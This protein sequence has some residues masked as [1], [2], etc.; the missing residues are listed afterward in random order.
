MSHSGHTNT[1]TASP[2]APAHPQTEHQAKPEPQPVHYA[3][4]QERAIAAGRDPQPNKFEK[5]GG[6]PGGSPA[7]ELDP[8]P[9]DAKPGNEGASNTSAGK[10]DPNQQPS[11]TG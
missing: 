11:R 4:A 10:P 2:A 8:P 9:K 1:K 3:T 5:T 6:C 7:R